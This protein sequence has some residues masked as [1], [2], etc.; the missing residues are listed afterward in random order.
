[1]SERLTRGFCELTLEDDRI[2]LACGEQAGVGALR[3]AG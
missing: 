3:E 2:W 1:M